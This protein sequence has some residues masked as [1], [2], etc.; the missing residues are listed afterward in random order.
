MK[1]Y[2]RADSSDYIN[3]D[4]KMFDPNVG[5]RKDI[6]RQTKSPELL[7]IYAYDPDWGVRLQTAWNSYTPADILFTLALDDDWHV[8]T[9]AY[10]NVNFPHSE[11]RVVAEQVTESRGGYM[12][13]RALI[14]DHKTDEDMLRILVPIA[15]YWTL[16]WLAKL[17][18]TP[19]SILEMLAKHP[20][21]QV[22][23]ALLK[24]KRLPDSIL[25]EL[26]DDP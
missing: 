11:D 26:Q 2:V 21:K 1:I 7:E 23:K 3:I 5:V 15:P 8:A 19:V 18:R 6:A 20:M 16:E 24:N 17:A 14:K 13:A 10:E 12:L 9:A 25:A 4:N 22:R